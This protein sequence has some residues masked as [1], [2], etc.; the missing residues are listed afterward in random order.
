VRRKKRKGERESGVDHTR[1]SESE[2]RSAR[3]E[4]ILIGS[5]L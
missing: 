5:I 2:A 1:S 3:C 4:M